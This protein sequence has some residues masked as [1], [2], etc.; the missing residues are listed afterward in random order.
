MGEQPLTGG[1]RAAEVVRVGDTVRRS[2]DEGADLAARVLTFL[3]SVGYPYAPRHLGIDERGRDILT[4]IPGVTTDH[5]GQ[6][7]PGAYAIGGRMLRA[8]HEVTSGHA[9]AAG[10]EC[11]VHGDPGP[12]NTIFRDGLPVAFID[13]SSCGPGAGLGDLAYLAWT[14]CIQAQGGVPIEEQALHLRELCDG[15]GAAVGPEELLDA[16]VGRQSGL[17]EAERAVIGDARFTDARR[18][19]AE[20]AIDWATG[21][22]RL[23]LRHRELLLTA[24]RGRRRS[25]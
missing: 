21:D 25:P 11:V 23:V 1:N 13:W 18:R 2:R 19:H 15:Y 16:V 5:P 20:A 9:L 6:R 8:L 10:Q 3:E 22:R 14:W 7:A 17:A 4:Y 12:F 24:L